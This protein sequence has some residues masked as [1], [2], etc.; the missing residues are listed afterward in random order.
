[1]GAHGD[2]TSDGTDDGGED[3]EVDDVDVEDK[4]QSESKGKKKATTTTATADNGSRLLEALDAAEKAGFAA[5]KAD[6]QIIAATPADQ[7]PAII[8]RLK[9]TVE[10]KGSGSGAEK[11][12]SG[13]R[14]QTSRLDES[15]AGRKG[16]VPPPAG[17]K[18][19]AKWVSD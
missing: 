13:Q 19:F 5:S 14:S 8:E 16:D 7:R 11:P 18:E 1:M 12:K 17:G 10:T 15:A 3:G 2:A 6:L 4:P 9:K